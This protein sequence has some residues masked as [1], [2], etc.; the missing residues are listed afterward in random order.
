MDMLKR[1]GSGD[2]H[3]DPVTGELKK[4]LLLAGPELNDFAAEMQA[5]EPSRFTYKESRWAKFPDGTDQIVLGGFTPNNVVRGSHIVFLANFKNN[6]V[7]LA[8][9]YALVVIAES[10]VESLTVVL[11]F[12][13]TATMERVLVEGEVATAATLAKML[14]NLPPIG[15]PARVM[16]YDLHTLQNRFYFTGNAIATLHTAF[17]LMTQQ[18]KD[19]ADADRITAVVFP[20]DGAQKRFQHMF[21]SVL[22]DLEIVVCSK[23]RD[24]DD[25]NVRKVVIADGFPK[26]KRCL[27][28]DDLVQTGGTLHECGKKLLEE[29]A[30]NVSAFVVHSVFPNESWKRFC[31]GGD[32][33]IFKYFFTTDSNRH[34]TGA[35]PTDDVFS[36]LKLV[37]QI[38]EDL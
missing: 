15:K 19:M 2:A 23:K 26:D 27:I 17:P 7:L 35:M 32:R 5:R 1:Y 14:S 16:L 12:F 9:Y 36:I 20:D 18:I 24:H 3:V 10:F 22:P 38:C 29:G 8:Q 33:N 13:P 21:T 28:V 37:P 31:R 11:P 4:Y 6:D 25:P 30:E 34:V